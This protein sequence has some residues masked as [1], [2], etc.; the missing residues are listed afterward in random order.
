MRQEPAAFAVRPLTDWALDP[1][2][3]PDHAVFVSDPPAQHAARRSRQSE[4]LLPSPRMARMARL[5][6]QE[7]VLE[8]LPSRASS[9]QEPAIRQT[10]PMGPA[11]SVEMQRRPAEPLGSAPKVTRELPRSARQAPGPG[12]RIPA[13]RQNLHSPRLRREP[14]EPPRRVEAPTAT[15]TVSQALKQASRTPIRRRN[16]RPPSGRMCCDMSGTASAES[17][18]HQNLQ[19]SAYFPKRPVEDAARKTGCSA[20]PAGTDLPPLR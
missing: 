12:Q 10:T 17:M 11:R 18:P 14:T 3:Q 1:P 5:A 7:L 16:A 9:P 13:A 8:P 19:K 2:I 20:N 4:A 6:A 15:I